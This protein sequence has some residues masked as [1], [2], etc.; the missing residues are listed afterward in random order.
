MHVMN[1]SM[2]GIYLPLYLEVYTMIRVLKLRA[3]K[4]TGSKETGLAT[5]TPL[6]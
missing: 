1:L 6:N 2:D 4:L 5:S 3:A